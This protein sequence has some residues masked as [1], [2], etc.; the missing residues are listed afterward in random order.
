MI[1]QNQSHD[2][3]CV[4]KVSNGAL[5][6]ITH[7]KIEIIEN[8]QGYTRSA[9]VSRAWKVPG[10]VGDLKLAPKMQ[11]IS[12]GSGGMLTQK[13]LKLVLLESVYCTCI[14]V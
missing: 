2:F 14:K 13:N 8:G 10:E 11:L 3:A 12:R 9:V 1:G 5:I 6:T 7:K 4:V